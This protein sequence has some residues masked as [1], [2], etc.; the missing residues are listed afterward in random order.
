[1]HTIPWLQQILDL[2]D[3]EFFAFWAMIFLGC[4]IVGFLIDAIMKKSAYGPGFNAV[5]ASCA[6][7]AGVYLRYKYLPPLYRF[8]PGVTLLVA[9]SA[10]LGFMIFLSYFR[11]AGL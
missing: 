7:V 6:A 2:E 8:E 9:V 5:L 1:M 3:F 4:L 11:R 10:G